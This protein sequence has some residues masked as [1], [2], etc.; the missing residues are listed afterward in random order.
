ML[1]EKRFGP[2]YQL[3]L[4]FGVLSLILCACGSGQSSSSPSSATPVTTRAAATTTVQFDP[5]YQCV[6][7][8]PQTGEHKCSNGLTVKSGKTFG[9]LTINNG[10]K[11]LAACSYTAE[12][13][14]GSM[15]YPIKEIRGAVVFVIPCTNRYTVV[16]YATPTTKPQEFLIEGEN[17]EIPIPVTVNGIGNTMTVHVRK[18]KFAGYTIPQQV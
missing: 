17:A 5:Y 7:V 12:Q 16:N 2:L 15:V 8:N 18:G 3:L 1:K 4:F 6:N 11:N 14:L 10:T 13:V 9:S